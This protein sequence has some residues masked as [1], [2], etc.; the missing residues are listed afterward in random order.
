M[1]IQAGRRARRLRIQSATTSRETTYGDVAHAWADVA[2]SEVWG[3]ITPLGGRER[4][5]AAAINP[6]ISHQIMIRYRSDVGPGMR[7]QTK[8]GTRTFQILDAI[9]REERNEVTLMNCIEEV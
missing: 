4:W 1:S 6:D 2:E 9:N 7:L 3:W 5:E 8:D